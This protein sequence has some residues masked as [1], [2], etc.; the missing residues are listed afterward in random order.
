MRIPVNRAIKIWQ[1]IKPQM[2]ITIMLRTT[3]GQ[4]QNIVIYKTTQSWNKKMPT[5]QKKIVYIRS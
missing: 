2:K 5:T 4:P 1:K 3:A